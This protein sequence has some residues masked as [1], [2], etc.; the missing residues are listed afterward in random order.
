MEYSGYKMDFQ[1]NDFLERQRLME[2]KRRILI[3]HQDMRL[4]QG[5]N[6]A[7]K[8]LSFRGKFKFLIGLSILLTKSGQFH[9]WKVRKSGVFSTAS[10][11]K[12]HCLNC[13]LNRYYFNLILL[14]LVITR[15]AKRHTA[16]AEEYLM[17]ELY[18]LTIRV[19]NMHAICQKLE[20]NQQTYVLCGPKRMLTF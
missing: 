4:K 7:F 1:M 17:R 18:P 14:Y 13:V 3:A 8:F 6:C 2:E 10:L 15:E 12:F 5:E 16:Q 20:Q 11:H 9:E 19:D